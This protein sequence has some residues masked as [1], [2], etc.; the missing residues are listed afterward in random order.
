MLVPIV[1][2]ATGAAA[3]LGV[4]L[5]PQELCGATYPAPTTCFIGRFDAVLSVGAACVV[6]LAVIV[7]AVGLLAPSIRRIVVVAGVAAALTA[8]VALIG[9]RLVLFGP[10]GG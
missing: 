10:L 7:V 6:A 3:L 4:R 5:G 2:A 9:A 1:V 8:T